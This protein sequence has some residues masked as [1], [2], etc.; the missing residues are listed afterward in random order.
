MYGCVWAIVDEVHLTDS[1]NFRVFVGKCDVEHETFA[2]ICKDSS[3][4]IY[5]RIEDNDGVWKKRD[6]LH[7]TLVDLVNHKKDS[8]KP[9]FGFPYYRLT[10]PKRNIRIGLCGILNSVGAYR[11]RHILR[12]RRRR[13]CDG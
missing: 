11:L 8:T 10:S 4:D 6:S 2:F 13:R 7:L 5:R 12:T 9:L 3:V 1:F